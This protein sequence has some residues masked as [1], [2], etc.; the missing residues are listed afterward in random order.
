MQTKLH[1]RPDLLLLLS[2]L[3]A[4][5]LTPELDRDG[6]RRLVL[7]GVTFIPV[8]VSTVRLSQIKLWVWPS[9]LLML[10]NMAFVVAG[11][12]FRSRALTGI[13]WGFLAAFFALDSSA[14]ALRGG[15]LVLID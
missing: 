3:L 4:I 7:A 10:V 8:I 1:S 6:W 9:V 14:C 15:A 5:L 12:T 11:N 2:L 13:R